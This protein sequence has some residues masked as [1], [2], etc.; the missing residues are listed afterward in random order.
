MRGVLLAG[1]G[2]WLII[3]PMSIAFAESSGNEPAQ[4]HRQTPDQ[5]IPTNDAD[6]VEPGK[7]GPGSEKNSQVSPTSP[8]I[9]A[10]KQPPPEINLPADTEQPKSGARESHDS[11]GSAGATT[12]PPAPPATSK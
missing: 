7:V 3:A 9:P 4:Q 6:H 12:Q 11:Q 8:D 5:T 10:H 1:A 2:A